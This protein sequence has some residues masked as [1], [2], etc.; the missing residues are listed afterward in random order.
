M[1]ERKSIPL[2]ESFPPGCEFWASFDGEDFVEYPDGAVLELSEDGKLLLDCAR[3]P[4]RTLAPMS[5][6]AFLGSAE[7]CRAFEASKAKS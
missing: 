4:M 5:E 1:F 6:S 3:L 2:P 7:S